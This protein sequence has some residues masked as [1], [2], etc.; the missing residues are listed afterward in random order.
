MCGR[1]AL[2]SNP[3]VVAL[4]FHL[5][6][7]PAFLPRY[8]IAP[9]AQILAIKPEGA[10]LL[11]WGWRGKAHNLRA[12]T[13]RRGRRCLIP[14]NGFYEWRK[15]GAG[16]QPYYVRPARGALFGFAGIWDEATCAILTVEAN[17]TLRAIHHRM[18]AIVA[19]QSYARWLGGDDD[20]L[21]PAPEEE[22]V[23]Y[24]VG[25]AINSGSAESPRLIEPSGID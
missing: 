15:V 6:A 24:P 19:P 25:P 7:V 22:T 23:A 3:E 9:A 10:V 17:R 21:A 4:Q 2:H 18:P 13:T 14:A 5:D 20:L 12:E 11:K 8:N 16:K 1:Y